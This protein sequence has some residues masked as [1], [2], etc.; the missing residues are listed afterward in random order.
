SVL[1]SNWKTFPPLSRLAT[2][3]NTRCMTKALS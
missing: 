3:W 2:R 1:K